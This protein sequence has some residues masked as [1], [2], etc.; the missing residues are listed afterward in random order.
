MGRKIKI[1]L[2]GIT[3][4]GLS[5]W[6]FVQESI[7]EVKI[8]SSA[9]TSF[10]RMPN[11]DKKRLTHL[12]YQILVR[13]DGAYT[14]LGSK[15]MSLGA[16]I[17]PFSIS[18]GWNVFLA[19]IHPSNRRVYQ[20]LKVWEKYAPMLKK[21]PFIIRAE[22][23]PYWPEPHDAIC[24]LLIDRNKFSE[25]IDLHRKDFEE[26]LQIKSINAGLLLQEASKSPLLK[27][28]LKGHDGLIGT[29]LG[30]GRNNAWLYE[31]RKHGQRI[32]MSSS[33]EPIIYSFFSNRPKFA[34]EYFGLIESDLSLVLGYPA[35]LA[36][37][38]SVETI[39]LKKSFLETR[40]K[41]LEYYEG[42]DF[43][44]ATLSLFNG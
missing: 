20:G 36:D 17:K 34:W 25:T 27:T 33:C 18:R 12:F 6:W 40:Q 24:I 44:E 21:S 35:F 29:L 2:I 37:P 39:E 15:P 31:Q 26:V 19:S 32:P 1:A 5:S 4:L 8:S 30:Y 43:L 16:V 10:I 9:Q 42:K 11:K 14:L 13:D 28:I 23:N 38:S 22:I 7:V 3:A 41:I